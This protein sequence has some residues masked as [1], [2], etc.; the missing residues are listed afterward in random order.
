MK[1]QE[2]A[3]LTIDDEAWVE[4]PAD[5]R[6]PF[7][8]AGAAEWVSYP[9]LEDLVHVQWFGRDGR[10]HM[11]DRSRRGIVAKAMG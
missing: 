3:A 2:L 1:F 5:W 8:P 7:L 6:A 4:A 11:G 9:A 10:P